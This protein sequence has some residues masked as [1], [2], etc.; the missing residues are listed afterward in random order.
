MPLALAMQMRTP[1]KEPGP[2]PQA[3]QEMASFG[4]PASSSRP[5]MQPKSFVLDA[6]RAATVRCAMH[7]M[8]LDRPQSTPRP[9][10]ITSFEVSNA[11]MMFFSILQ[12][13]LR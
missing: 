2:R 13:R 12:S 7:S 10:A 8:D 11:R 6:R 9:M 4:T 3:M 5:S 1:V